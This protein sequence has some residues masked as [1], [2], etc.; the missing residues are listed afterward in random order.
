M[1]PSGPWTLTACTVDSSSLLPPT[2]KALPW[3]AINHHANSGSPSRASFWPTR[4]LTPSSYTSSVWGMRISPPMS[5]S[6]PSAEVE[7][8]V[9]AHAIAEELHISIPSTAIVIATISVHSIWLLIQF[10]IVTR[11]ILSY[12]HPLCSWEGG[13]GAVQ[14][15]PCHLSSSGH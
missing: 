9:V 1:I 14:S 8:R 4:S 10:I 15:L 13:F 6:R 7:Y 5:L 2:Y 12:W 11:C 3:R